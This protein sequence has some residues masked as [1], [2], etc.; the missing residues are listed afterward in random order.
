MIRDNNEINS[1]I[2]F[3]GQG[4]QPRNHPNIAKDETIMSDRNYL[5]KKNSNAEVPQ[6][7]PINQQ[8]NLQGIE[9]TDALFQ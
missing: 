9:S 7:I 8:I 2:S 1:Q 6:N 4:G 3:G 5:K